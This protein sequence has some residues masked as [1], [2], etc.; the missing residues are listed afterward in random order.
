MHSTEYLNPRQLRPGGVLVVGAGNSG[1]EIALELARAGH[2]TWVSGPD[3]GAVPFNIQGLAAR[4]FLRQ[5]V[6]RVVFHRVLTLSTPIG[7][8]ARLSPDRHRTPLIRTKRRD[9]GAVG[10]EFVERT[11]GVR[12]G[13]PVLTD[14]RVLDANN[15]IWCTGFD[16]GLSWLDVPVF[17]ADGTPREHRGVVP[18]EPGLYFVGRDFQYAMSSTMI[19]GV[20]RDAD[21]VSGVIDGRARTV[22]MRPEP[23]A[24]SA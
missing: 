24:L 14:G 22:P 17:D 8:K 6:F 21:Y 19:H 7:R 16:A 13:R 18:D 4:L 10:V 20:G 5:L 3:V 23:V 9:L 15:V 2:A 1:A 11:A 12:E